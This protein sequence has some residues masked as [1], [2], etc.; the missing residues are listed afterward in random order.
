MAGK[1]ALKG[2]YFYHFHSHLKLISI[3]NISELKHGAISIL[4]VFFKKRS[5]QGLKKKK[6]EREKTAK[7]KLNHTRYVSIV[8]KTS[9]QA[10]T[11]QSSFTNGSCP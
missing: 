9:V 5:I 11:F 3:I 2:E 1:P 7:L 8:F 6:R 10:I 4:L